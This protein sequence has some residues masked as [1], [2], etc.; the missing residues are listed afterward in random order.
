MNMKYLIALIAGFIACKSNSQ[1]PKVSTGSIKLITQFKSNYVASRDIAVWLPENY[2]PSKKYA[3]LYMND[4]KS[5]FDSTLMWNKQEWGVD[6]VLGRLMA[7]HQ[8][9]DCIVVGI[10]NSG[11]TRHSEYC[12]QKPFEMLKPAEQDSMYTARRKDHSIFFATKVF[13]DKYLK[14]IVEELKPFIDSSFSTY[15]DVANTFI[16]GSS[17]GGVNSWYAITEYPEVFGG[18]ACL[19]IH[20]T[21]IYSDI[22]NPL[23]VAELEYLRTH[24]PMPANHKLYFDYGTETLDTLYKSYQL[25]ADYIYKLTGYNDTNYFSKEFFGAD[26]SENAWRARLNFPMLFLLGNKK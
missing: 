7:T 9:R 22:D 18:A 3:V 6:E 19:S 21:G 11:A 25:D 1:V 5:L 2:S 14:F 15:T 13:S 24:I 26:H 8:I 20:W 4:G 23:P 16:A 17:M 10:Y 12:P